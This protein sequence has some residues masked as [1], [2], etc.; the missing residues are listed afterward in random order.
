MEVIKGE[1]EQN[2]GKKMQDKMTEEKINTLYS[3][4]KTNAK[5]TPPYSV[6]KPE[7]SSDSD[8]EKSKG[9][10]WVSARVVNTQ[11]GK[12][13][14]TINEEQILIILNE[15]VE[16]TTNTTRERVVNTASQEMDWAT[17]R[18]E[19]IKEYLELEDQ[20]PRRTPKTIIEPSIMNT[21]N[22]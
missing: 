10:R 9:A 4:K 19:P 22:E 6:L 13:Y 14:S 18:K 1:I 2:K 3:D 12:I 20:P 8:S 5:Q 16:K 7:T 17:E 21:K 11:I 15:Q